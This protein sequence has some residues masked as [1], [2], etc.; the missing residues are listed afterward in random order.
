MRTWTARFLDEV[1]FVS[2]LTYSLCLL[3][4]VPYRNCLTLELTLLFPRQHDGP[5]RISVLHTRIQPPE[6][7][8]AASGLR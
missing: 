5:F 1:Q 7:N 4:L 3:Q 6:I 8:H 2:Q